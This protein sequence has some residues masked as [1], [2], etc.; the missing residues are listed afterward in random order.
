MKLL[1]YNIMSG[2]F[3]DYKTDEV[4]PVRMDK[5][6][7]AVKNAGTD[8]VAL[9][10]TYRWREK[11][12]KQQLSEWFGYKSVF[13]AAMDDDSSKL[14]LEL[15]IMTNLEIE[16]VDII[17][18][19]NRNCIK[20]KV[21]NGSKECDIFAVHLEWTKED[22]RVKQIEALLKQTDPKIPT[23]IMGD[24]NTIA[25]RDLTGLRKI[26]LNCFLSLPSLRKT[27]KVIFDMERG[28]VTEI[29]KAKGFVDAN[30]YR[31]KTAPSKLF[32]VWV[33]PALIRLD[34]AFCSPEIKVKSF[35]VLKGPIYDYT[36]D[37][38]PIMIEVEI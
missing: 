11:F 37:H 3:G 27:G 16:K 34:Y 25:S 35:D 14:Q 33:P 1:A 2:G 30:S 22:I 15:T 19:Y 26:I 31:L 7:A 29:I 23:I 12:S 36:S 6:I 32:P 9:I 18:I 10:D 20:A 17:R 38:Y 8:F 5:I 28:L 24:F 4:Y 21:K 13:S